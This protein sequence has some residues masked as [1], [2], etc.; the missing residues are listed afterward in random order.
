[1]K[2]GSFQATQP[3]G[4]CDPADRKLLLALSRDKPCGHNLHA[5]AACSFGVLRSPE[6]LPVCATVV[7]F[8]AETSISF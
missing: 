4:V 3:C 2:A 8:S 1:M 7:L 5:S 6:M